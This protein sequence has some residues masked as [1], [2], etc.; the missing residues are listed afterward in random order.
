M[1]VFNESITFLKCLETQK[2]TTPKHKRDPW[3]FLN[4]VVSTLLKVFVEYNAGTPEINYN[5][6]V[7]VNKRKHAYEK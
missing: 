3:I 1:Q 5:K 4:N 6:T 2:N 7:F